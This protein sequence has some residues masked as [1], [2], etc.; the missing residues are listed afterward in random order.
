MGGGGRKM[1][2]I[3]KVP[4]MNR[5]KGAAGAL[6]KVLLGAGIFGTLL[7]NSYYDV[8]GGQQAIIFNRFVGIREDVV[9]EGTHFLIPFLE[10][11]IIFDVKTRPRN[12]QAFS[13]TKD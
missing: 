12:I 6:T 4:N 5:A 3:P 2:K 8:E 11:P 13:G 9:D 10:W 1:P 7:Y